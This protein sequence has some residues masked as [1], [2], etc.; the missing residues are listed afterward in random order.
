MRRLLPMLLIALLPSYA[1]GQAKSPAAPP[2]TVSAP[3]TGSGT[4]ASPLAV[5]GLSGTNTG[6]VTLVNNTNGLT[7]SSQALTMGLAT[8]AAAGTVSTTTQT[9][10]GTKTFSGEID[11]SVASGSL[12][13]QLLT[14]AKFCLGTG[15]LA[16]WTYNGSYA[17]Q[18]LPIQAQYFLTTHTGIAALTSGITGAQYVIDNGNGWGLVNGGTGTN[19]DVMVLRTSGAATALTIDGSATQLTTSA[20]PLHC[21]STKTVGTITL[22]SGSGTATV[23]SGAVCVCTDAASVLAAKCAVSGTTLT[24]TV[25]AGGSD[26]VNYICL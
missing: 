10:A 23:F 12:A 2:L 4:V 26:T 8:G 22:S 6:D 17:V 5:T 13:L 15:S 18:T 11:S 16:C 19:R 1:L 7:I 14:G 20:L 25:T 24:A 9:F 21:T 3:I